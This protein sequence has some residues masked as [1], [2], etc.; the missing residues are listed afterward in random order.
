MLKN[1]SIGLRLMLGFGIVVALL[2]V[3]SII[4]IQQMGKMDTRMREI[5]DINNAEKDLAIKMRINLDARAI[6]LRDVT[7]LPDGQARD[8]VVQR[9]KKLRQEF[10]EQYAKLNGM[11]K[12]YEGEQREFKQMEKIMQA[13]QNALQVS[14]AMISDALAGKRNEA[15]TKVV[16]VKKAIDAIRTEM[17]TLANIE[18]E[19]NADAVKAAQSAYASAKTLLIG[20]LLTALVVAGLAALVVTRSITRPVGHV[21]G[22][23]EKIGAGDLS[24]ALSAEGSD[25]IARLV[26]GVKNMNEAL[27]QSISHVRQSANDVADTSSALSSA[28]QQVRV[29]SENQ[30]EAASAMAAA[31]EEMSASINHVSNLS[32]DARNLAQTSSQEASVGTGHIAAMVEEIGKVSETIEE[33]ATH[34]REL[35]QESER[36]SRIVSVIKEVADQTNLLALNAAIEAAR[37]GEMGR[38]FAVVADEVRKLAE[39]S[40]T[41]AQEITQMVSTIQERTHAM[42]DRMETTVSQMREGMNIARSAGDSIRGIDDGAR[43]VTHVIDDVATALKEQAAASHDLANRVERIVQMIEQ[44][45]SAVASVASSAD[46][47]EGLSGDLVQSV[48]RFR[49]S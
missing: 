9:L 6:A 4:G 41:S 48:A 17:E 18:D 31:L 45:T 10:D 30:S 28:A 24:V 32:D 39:R 12:A 1:I 40:A 42:S 14:G 34:A 37:A 38:G 35:G 49:I 47:L 5:T 27:R 15:Q 3:M 29:G 19:M 46:G 25:E 11:F 8:E 43:Q 16:E 13:Q 2:L 33:S 23:V 26:G 21:L 7:I 22:A 20:L 44:N 36:I